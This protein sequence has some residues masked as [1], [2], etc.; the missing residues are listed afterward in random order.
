KRDGLGFL[1][2]FPH[3]HVYQVVKVLALLAILRY[4]VSAKR[5]ARSSPTNRIDR[6]VGDYTNTARL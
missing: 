4:S 6:Q 1:G 2:Y 3:H 5:I